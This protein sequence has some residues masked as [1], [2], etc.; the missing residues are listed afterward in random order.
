MA[1]A[2]ALL[3]RT[4]NGAGAGAG[5]SAPTHGAAAVAVLADAGGKAPAAPSA[6]ADGAA[7]A[8]GSAPVKPPAATD[9]A[10]AEDA[11][12]SVPTPLPAVLGSAAATAPMC[13]AAAPV[14]ADPVARFD[15]A[16]AVRTGR[17]EKEGS[18]SALLGY[19]GKN[20]K[21]DLD[22]VRSGKSTRHTVVSAC[23]VLD[24]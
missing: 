19:S 12:P 15:A 21:R 1:E 16:V 6:T 7:S 3:E 8:D 20:G 11:A 4:L 14:P 17:G 2:C 5:K 13:T 22:N 18:I 23:A 9:A 24:A 10:F